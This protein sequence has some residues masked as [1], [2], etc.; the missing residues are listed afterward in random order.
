MKFEDMKIGQKI[1]VCI[2]AAILGIVTALSVFI[3]LVLIA[4][5]AAWTWGL[6]IDT[7]G[8]LL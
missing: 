6:F 8:G 3:V 4:N 1:I 5:V 7:L 2:L